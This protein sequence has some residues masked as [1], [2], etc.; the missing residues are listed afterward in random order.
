M[1]A[2]N[3]DSTGVVNWLGYSAY[4]FT[5]P[6]LLLRNHDGVVNNALMILVN[7]GSDGVIDNSLTSFVH[8]LANG[9]VYDAAVRFV[10]WLAYGVV[11]NTAVCF[12]HRLHDGVVHNP[13]V[14]LV[15]R[16]ANC[17]VNFSLV[18][19]VHGTLYGVVHLTRVR[20]VNWLHNRILS[21]LCLVN[22]LT[23][24]L[25]DRPIARLLLHASDVDYLVLCNVLV[26]SSRAL[27]GF[28]FVNRTS[29]CLH[30]RVSCWNLAAIHDGFTT[31]LIANRTA[32][33]GVSFA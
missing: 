7:W 12:V 2:L 32:V 30:D 15:H 16:L 29:H 27:F 31:I 9:V 3:L 5:R 8:R 6:L 26:L 20:L 17:V 11:N 24:S 28:L 33:C 14:S 18:C 23:H 4:N 1:A 19:F 25:V 22:W 10:N 21:C 13:A